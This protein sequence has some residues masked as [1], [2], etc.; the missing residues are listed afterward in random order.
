MVAG[1]GNKPAKNAGEALNMLGDKMYPYFD[2]YLSSVAVTRRIEKEDIRAIRTVLD[3]E[4][5]ADR[6]V[7]EKLIELDRS[8][9][10]DAEWQEFLAETIADFAVWVEGPLGKVSA[11]TSAWLIAMLGGPSGSPAPSAAKVVHAVIAE[12]EEAD[13][14][15]TLFALSTPQVP[16]WTRPM[17]RVWSRSVDLVI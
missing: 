16:Y 2:E 4:V 13:A 11:Q 14:S 6:R 15:L 12:A 1:Q 7:I 5:A 3:E 9:R 17:S 8:A 10:G